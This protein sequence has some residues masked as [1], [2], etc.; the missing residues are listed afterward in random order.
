MLGNKYY[1][2]GCKESGEKDFD[3]ARR[4]I[5]RKFRDEWGVKI[6]RMQRTSLLE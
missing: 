4:A 6:I 5:M 1:L 2:Q 3:G